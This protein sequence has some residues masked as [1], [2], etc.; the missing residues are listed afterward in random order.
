MSQEVTRL[1][2]KSKSRSI[3]VIDKDCLW[4]GGSGI[5]PS[6]DDMTFFVDC[7]CCVTHYPIIEK[8]PKL[9]GMSDRDLD[10]QKPCKEC[11]GVGF[12]KLSCSEQWTLHYANPWYASGY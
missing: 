11:R 10:E 8:Q 1:S 3:K 2:A 12:H 6:E 7:L 9:K 5:V 4:C